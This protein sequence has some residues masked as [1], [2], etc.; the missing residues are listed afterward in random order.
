MLI[1]NDKWNFLKAVITVYYVNYINAI[2]YFDRI[3]SSLDRGHVTDLSKV[4]GGSVK[5]L[6]SNK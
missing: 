4:L 6:I 2:P 5:Y 1:N 3:S